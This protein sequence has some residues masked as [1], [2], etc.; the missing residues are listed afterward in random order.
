MS[1]LDRSPGDGAS[2]SPG[3]GQV[4]AVI[5]RGTGDGSGAPP[6]MADQQ[7]IDPSTSGRVDAA[8]EGVVSAFVLGWHIAELFH[9]KVPGSVRRRQASLE[10]LA[11]IGELDPLAQARLLL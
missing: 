4:A 9:S 10:K 2:R 3:K 7:A 11:G 1:E 8:G 6:A 5:Q